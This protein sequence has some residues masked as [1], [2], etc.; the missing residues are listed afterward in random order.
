MVRDGTRKPELLEIFFFFFLYLNKWTI[1]EHFVQEETNTGILGFSEIQNI[2][3][4]E[5]LPKPF[6]KD[7][8]CK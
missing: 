8:I 7:V 4:A 6:E 5:N 2:S 1:L 3:V